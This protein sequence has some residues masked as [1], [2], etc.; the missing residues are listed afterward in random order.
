M[1][2]GKCE[3]HSKVLYVLLLSFDNRG[4]VDHELW[5]CGQF[6]IMFLMLTYVSGKMRGTPPPEAF[7]IVGRKFE[8][9]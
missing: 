5:G 2:D 3:S 6:I 1:L 4:R 7:A 8:T 9:E